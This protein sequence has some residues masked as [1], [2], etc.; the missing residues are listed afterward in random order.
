[1][2]NSNFELPVASIGALEAREKILS[3]A[4][5]V[6]DYAEALLELAKQLD[7]G[8]G[9]FAHLEEKIVMAQAH[10]LDDRKSRGETLGPLFGVPV[11][12]KDIIDTL[13]YPTEMGSPIHRGRATRWDATV[14]QRLRAAGALIFGKTVTTEFA[15]PIPAKTVNPHNIQHTPGGSSSGS[16]AAVA[17]GMLPVTIGTQTNGSIIRPASF[18]GVYGFK[19]SA[20]LIP[21][22]GIFEQS[23]TLDQVGVFGRSIS[24]IAGI[25]ESIIG[26]DGD[27]PS[28]RGTPSRA[29]QQIASEA[30]PFPPTLAYIQ[31]PY[32]SEVDV[33]SQQA[34]TA[35]RDLLSD[36]SANID[37]PESVTEVSKLLALIQESEMANALRKEYASHRTLL[38]A[39]LIE[40]VERGRAHQAIDYLNAIDRI[41]TIR[42]GFDEFFERFDAL[43]TPAALGPA[44]QGLESTGNPIMATMWSYCGMPAISLPLLQSST[45]MP[46]GVQLIGAKGDDARLLRTANWLVNHLE[47][48]E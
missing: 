34:F 2:A 25:C 41:E 45:G 16:A 9:A 26:D 15:T 42:E 14:V 11:G 7:S 37:L 48:A 30:P 1:M 10:E 17:A 8:I 36:H 33:E 29:L 35:L 43:I 19:P 47:N 32:W 20:G 5:S 28:C 44:P 31:T 6:A 24:D 18:C 4:F 40:M 21:R 38:S 3:G 23:P 13:D 46:I 22:T 12:I 27:D 39:P